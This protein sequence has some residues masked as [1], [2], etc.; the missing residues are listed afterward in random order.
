MIFQSPY[1]KTI[2][3]NPHTF[4]SQS[5]EIPAQ[6]QLTQTLSPFMTP[7][8]PSICFVHSRRDKGKILHEKEKKPK[9]T[10]QNR[11]I[12]N[13]KF[14]E[15][16]ESLCAIGAVEDLLSRKTIQPFLKLETVHDKQVSKPSNFKGAPMMTTFVCS[17]SGC[18]GQVW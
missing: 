8:S 2:L 17:V 3:R 13:V 5:P 12:Q 18:T 9:K 14:L 15:L 1:Q 11:L 6:L 7:A 16:W 10:Q 4:F